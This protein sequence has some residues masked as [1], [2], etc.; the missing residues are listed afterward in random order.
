[1]TVNTSIMYQK[2]QTLEKVIPDISSAQR[3]PN[4]FKAP[5]RFTNNFRITRQ[6]EKFFSRLKG[7]TPK[8]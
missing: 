6:I 5:F 3:H 2:F 4:F 8:T 1:M 7:C